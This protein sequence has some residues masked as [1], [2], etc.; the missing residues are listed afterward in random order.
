MDNNQKNILKLE[1]IR[2]TIVKVCPQIISE[3]LEWILY[4]VYDRSDSF[5][6]MVYKELI[7]LLELEDLKVTL[8]CEEDAFF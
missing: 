8:S 4:Q 2:D 1:Q 6:L 3:Q 7:Q 5:E